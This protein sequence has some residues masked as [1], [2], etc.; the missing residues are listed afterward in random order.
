MS[1]ISLALIPALPA[2]AEANISATVCGPDMA[3]TLT[4]NS[5]AS[6][7]VTN[8]ADVHMHGQVTNANQINIYVDDQYSS[9]VPLSDSSTSY[10][11]TVSINTGTHTIKLIA[12]NICQTGNAEALAILTFEPISIP[13]SG[14]TVTT[15]TPSVPSA[16]IP[17]YLPKVA[18]VQRQSVIA[19]Y[20]ENPL[21][22][23]AHFLGLTGPDTSFA[24]PGTSTTPNI[25]RFSLFVLGSTI[26]ITSSIVSSWLPAT[27]K[28][29]H[30]RLRFKER[31]L[32]R[33]R[34]ALIGIGLIPIILMF[35]L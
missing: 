19:K 18:T 32:F 27:A 1:V 31:A 21:I 4:I 35:T 7:S 6:D 29:M 34:M 5:P 8:S 11:T 13:S 14:S 12:I 20:I 23:I 15:L 33:G 28:V 16:N 2:H 25:V 22:D 10:D 24:Q 17:K 3:S 26:I 9:V 30:L